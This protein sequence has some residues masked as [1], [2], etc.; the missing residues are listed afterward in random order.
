MGLWDNERVRPWAAEFRRKSMKTNIVAGILLS[1]S[2]V[3]LGGC[4]SGQPEAGESEAPRV[5]IRTQLITSI[6]PMDDRHLFVKA[7]GRDFF[8]AT[9]ERGCTDLRHARGVAVADRPTRICGDGFSFV[10]YRQPA[11]GLRRCRIIGIVPVESKD[12]VEALIR[13]REAEPAVADGEAD[14]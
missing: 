10:S 9:V 3:L 14:G 6:T 13:S 7:V 5:C 2:V 4:V 12:E 1:A 8:L 11:T